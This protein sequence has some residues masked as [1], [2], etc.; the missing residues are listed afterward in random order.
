MLAPAFNRKEKEL[1]VLKTV[2]TTGEGIDALA[3]AID[4]HLAGNYNNDHALW[5]LTEK[6]WQLIS[7]KRM[8]DVEKADLYTALS[9]AQKPLNI[10][11]FIKNY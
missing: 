10:Y 3:E 4:T 11:D 2:A 7:K 6:A 1:P 9:R 8:R 5:L